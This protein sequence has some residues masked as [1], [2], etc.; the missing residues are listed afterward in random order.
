VLALAWP[1]PLIVREGT[2]NSWNCPV[3][4]YTT[5]K[6]TQMIFAALGEEDKVGFTHY[7]VGHC[8]AGGA[9]WSSLYDAFVQRFIRRDDSVST[10][11]M[12]TESFDFAADTWHDGQLPAS[13][14]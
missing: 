14:P 10:A 9:E 7:N 11:G 5:L 2:N 6:Y 13:I 1:R 3:C 8:E 12:F 4:V